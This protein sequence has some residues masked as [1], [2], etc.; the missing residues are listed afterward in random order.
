MRRW[1]SIFAT[2]PRM[3]PCMVDDAMRPEALRVAA[4]SHVR[5]LLAVRD[6]LSAGDLTDG[7]KFEGVRYPL[8]NPQRGIFKPRQMRN[9]LSIRTVFPKRGGK[10]WYDDQREVHRQIYDGEDAVDY[11]FMVPIPTQP[12]IDGC[13]KRWNSRCRSSISWVSHRVGTK[14]SFQ[15]S[16]WTGTR[17]RR[18]CASF[19]GMRPRP[20]PRCRLS[21][22]PSVDMHC[23]WC[24]DACIRLRFA[25]PSSQPIEGGVPCRDCLNLCFSMPRTLFPTGTNAS[26]SP[27]YRM[28]S[29]YRRFTMPRSML[30][31]SVSIQTSR[32]T[33]RSA[34]CLS[35]T[36]RYSRP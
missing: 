20:Q 28:A 15:R 31:C 35:T 27:S 6:Q 10:V 8:V 36:A 1:L 25:M 23:R 19:L 17:A 30:I 5:Q 16:L 12:R 14:Q 26:V 34:C 29:L 11:A 7:F 21:I 4:F 22:L 33:S 18:V 13:V 9:L 24:S 3:L 32:Y 2:S